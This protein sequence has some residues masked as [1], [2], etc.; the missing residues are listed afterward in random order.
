MAKAW[1]EGSAGDPGFP[2]EFE[3]K[4]KAVLQVTDIKTNKNKYYCLEV[5]DA[6][7][8]YRLYTHYGRTDDLEN[9]PAA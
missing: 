5:H 4:Q 1:K 3:V 2:E 9:N 6:G 8:N 7:S